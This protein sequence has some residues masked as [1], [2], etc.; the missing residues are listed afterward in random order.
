[1]CGVADWCCFLCHVSSVE[2]GTDIFGS[3]DGVFQ[4]NTVLRLVRAA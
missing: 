4:N 2:W 3:I 1:M